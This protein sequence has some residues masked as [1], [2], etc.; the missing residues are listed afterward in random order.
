MEEMLATMEQFLVLVHDVTGPFTDTVGERLIFSLVLLGVAVV[1]RKLL[2][3]AEP[4][5][6]GYFDQYDTHKRFHWMIFAGLTGL[7]VNTGIYSE[8]VMYSLPIVVRG[9]APVEWEMAS[10]GLVGILVFISLF[11][12]L[13]Y[14]IL[15]R[16]L[17]LF[18]RPLS[19]HLCFL[20]LGMVISPVMEYVGMILNEKLGFGQFLMTI[21]FIAQ[22]FVVAG[23]AI[24]M[25]GWFFM[26]FFSESFW[27]Q[28]DAEREA[29]ERRN[30]KASGNSGDSDAGWGHST[31]AMPDII[32]DAYG[33]IYRVC[34]YG[35][36]EKSYHCATLGH[37]VT[38]RDCDIDLT[39]CSAYADGEHLYW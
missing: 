11:R 39:A 20:C 38:V 28:L 8:E 5:L 7:I 1:I 29:R 18:L 19:S 9:S 3:N 36:G 17:L 22:M 37:T 16:N 6:D 27:A 25:V 13:L 10:L 32:R 34:G 14:L 2:F 26:S 31:A 15:S 30:R 12:G 21:Y 24:W 4:L 33:N 35:V 23:A